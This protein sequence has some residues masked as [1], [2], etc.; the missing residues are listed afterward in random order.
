MITIKCKLG[1]ERF[2]LAYSST[3]KSITEG[4]SGQKLK[5]SRTLKVGADVEAM[6][7]T[8]LLFLFSFRTHGHHSRD[9][10]TH[11]G[12]GCYPLIIN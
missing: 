9:G 2:Y 5:Q 3:S 6:L 8:G 1:Q 4:S 11:N 12:L 10:V 7:L